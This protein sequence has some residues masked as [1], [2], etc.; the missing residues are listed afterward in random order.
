ML[1]IAV[2][3]ADENSFSSHFTSYFTFFF[4]LTLTY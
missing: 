2:G 1:Y 3:A 4:T